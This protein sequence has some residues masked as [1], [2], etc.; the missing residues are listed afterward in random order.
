MEI[1][2]KDGMA[3]VDAKLTDTDAID[4]VQTHSVCK[5]YSIKL[6][7]GKS[8]QI[9]M[10]SKDVDSF[11]RLEDSAEKELA[12]DD[13]SGGDHNARIQ[14]DCPA[15]GTYRIIATTYFGGAG[16]FTLVVKQK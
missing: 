11:L 15:D 6:V 2:L 12:K 14:F 1:N 13:D 9:D 7:K 16:D 8:Y 10:M 4:A 3:K 5:I